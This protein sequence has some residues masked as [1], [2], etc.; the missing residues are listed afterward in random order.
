MDITPL[1]KACVKTVRLRNKKIPQPDK[2]RI[3]KKKHRSEIHIKSKDICYQITQV[4]LHFYC[5]FYYFLNYF[6]LIT[7]QGFFNRE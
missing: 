5:L 7:G 2:N 3:L 4:K 1:F 6:H